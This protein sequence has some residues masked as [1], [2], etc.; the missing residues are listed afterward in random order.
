MKKIILS[1][2]LLAL[3]QGA[4]AQ[5]GVDLGYYGFSDLPV[6]TAEEEMTYQ[7]SGVACLYDGRVFD[8]RIENGQFELWESRR[9]VNKVYKED[10]LERYSKFY[11]PDVKEEDILECNGRY[12]D[13][14]GKI[15]KLY[16]EDIR[17]IEEDGE[18]YM[19]LQFDSA[20]IGG[21]FDCF[22]IIRN[23]S[24]PENGNNIFYGQNPI[25]TA[26]F[27]IASPDFLKFDISSYNGLSTAT[28]TVIEKQE[29]RFAHVITHD[30]PAKKT[31]SAAFND[32]YYPTVQFV[33]SYNY[34]SSRM[35]FN[36]TSSYAANFASLVE[37]DKAGSKGLKKLMSSMKIDKK[38]PLLDK[39]RA[40][41][42]YVKTE[43]FYI[44]INYS[45]FSDPSS[46]LE[47]KMAN[48]L[49]LT[50][51][52][53]NLFVQFEIDAQIV[54][55]TNRTSTTFDPKF[56]GPN[57]YQEVLFY[58]PTLDVYLSPDYM[59]H[60]VGLV[61]SSLAAQQGL[62][63]TPVSV[64]KVLSFVPEFGDIIPLPAEATGDSLFV[65]I[66]VNTEEKNIEGKLRRAL[67]GY[68]APR[69]QAQWEEMEEEDRQSFIDHYV[70]L[71]TESV[72]VNDL[73]VYN[74]TSKDIFVKPFVIT[75][76]I[77]DYD[78]A[79]FGAGKIFLEVGKLIGEQSEFKQEGERVLPVQ[80]AYNSHYY[81]EIKIEVPEGYY[82][83][84]LKEIEMAVYDEDSPSKANAA[85]IV[86]ATQE[87][88]MIVIVSKEF[89]GSLFYPASEYKKCQLVNNAAA[90]FNNLKLIF[91]KQ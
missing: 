56:D 20:K 19:V 59:N 55:T 42:D 40:I 73:Q 44:D 57:F 33:L 16:K 53:H 21:V 39:I 26:E 32:A 49:G 50:R 60:R 23:K 37:L 61:P 89:Y 65:N 48:T 34:N 43:F 64:G 15:T 7:E 69:I 72:N 82:C 70:A 80:R 11:L 3:L 63:L 30:I 83:T 36:T 10:K 31:E 28:D 87:G 90:D 54:L 74:A 45:L 8:Y 91:D 81:R 76:N 88:N 6:L 85:F 47:N 38:L 77:S 52:F 78:L 71:G 9:F 14:N 22:Y 67:T 4:V 17:L 62:F 79:K 66:K 46:I 58:F 35:R 75:A 5:I 18:E 41:E 29:R 2:A 51:I 24:L 68:H 84:N 12:I 27:T 1:I 13:Q 86:T 25:K